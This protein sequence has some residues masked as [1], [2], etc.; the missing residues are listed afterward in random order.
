MYL[1]S[2]FLKAIKLSEEPKRREWPFFNLMDV[3]FSDQVNDPTLRLFSSTKTLGA[4]TLDER[5]KIE[6]DPIMSQALAAAAAAGSLMDISDIIQES[7]NDQLSENNC[8]SDDAKPE[9][10]YPYNNGEGSRDYEDSV[11]EKSRKNIPHPSSFMHQHHN[12]AQVTYL[13]I[14]INSLHLI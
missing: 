5:I 12:I 2:L 9:T 8:G 14:S 13:S 6:D 7:Q 1:L 10:N 4:D 3:Y 11:H